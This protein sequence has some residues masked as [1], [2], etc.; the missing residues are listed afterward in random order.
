MNSKLGEAEKQSIVEQYQRGTSVAV[1]CLK[2]GIPQSL[3]LIHISLKRELRQT[4]PLL[5][6]LIET[7]FNL[8]GFRGTSRNLVISI[9]V[10]SKVSSPHKDKIQYKNMVFMIKI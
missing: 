4:E 3:S 10:I 6:T 5:F 2:A 9:L 8:F 1:L 7:V